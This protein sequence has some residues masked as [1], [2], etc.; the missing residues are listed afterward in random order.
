LPTPLPSFLASFAIAIVG[1]AGGLFSALLVTQGAPATL[2][3]FRTSVQRLL[4]RPLVG[5]LVAVVVYMALSWQVV[6]GIEVTNGGT[7]IV[8]GFVTG[9]SERYILRLLNVTDSDS[10]DAKPSPPVALTR[11]M[12][13]ART[14]GD[15]TAKVAV[16]TVRMPGESNL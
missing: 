4:L 10:G 16:P 13:A 15:P 8:V 3:D 5:A 6:P 12:A 9:F 7:F 2:L 11:R 14:A 1:G